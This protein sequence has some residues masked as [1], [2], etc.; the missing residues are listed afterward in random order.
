MRGTGS[1]A[2]RPGP[3]RPVPV[4]TYRLQVRPEFGYDDAAAVVDHLAALGVGHAYLSPVLQPTPGSA[5]GY[6]VVDHS[7][8]NEE[9]GGR[10]AFER[11]VDALHE[12]G[13]GAVADVVPNHMAV[14]TPANLNAAL[15]SVLR[16]GPRSPFARWF[17]VDWDS[18]DHALLMPVL[19]SRIGQVLGNGELSLDTSGDEPLLRYYD[20]VF[21]VRPG[22]ESLGLAELVDRQWYRLAHWRV[23]DEELNYRRFFDVDTLAA[24]RV[25]DPEVFDATHELL[26]ELL[27]A[28]RL[29]GLRIDH[30]DGL[31]DPRGYLHR[32]AER[33]GRSWVVVEKILEGDERLP[34]DWET[35]GTTGYDALLRIGGLFVDPQGAGPLQ[36]LLDEV[37]AEDDQ[38]QS[39]FHAVVERA[40]REVV[41][42]G[43][44]AEV[45]RLTDLLVSICHA[46][47]RLR[48]HTARALRECVVELLVAFDRY[49]AYVVP[50]EPAPP[51]A[52]AVL[53]HAA[54]VARDHL[55]EDRWETLEVVC[56]LLLGREVGTAG[57]RADLARAELVIRFQQTCGPVM[58]KGV[59]DTAF[60]RWHRLV[61]L[62]EVGGDPERLGVPADELHAW[63]GDQV[64][65]HPTAMTTL[66]THDTKRSEDVRARL[67][68][69]AE[70]PAEWA[71]AVR[72]WRTLAEPHRRPQLDGATEYLIWQ[73]LVG[74]WSLG[75]ATK[76]GPIS[77]DR[78]VAYLEKAVREA[79]LH[80]TWTSQDE[81][82]EDAVRGFATGVLGDDDVL[83]AVKAYCERTA[84]AARVAVL[85]QK[86]VQLT[87]PGVPDVYQGTELVDLSLVDPDNR[88]P[89]DYE[90]RRARL[91]RLDAGGH[92][93]DLDDEK[94]LVTSRALRVRREHPEAFVGESTTYAPLPTSTGH[95][96]AFARGDADGPRAVTL[97]TRLPL[98]LARYG[99]W[100]AHTVALPEGRWVDAL[101]GR[102]LPGGPVALSEALG[103]LPLALLVRR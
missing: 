86:L 11:L 48:D 3:G 4:S 60:Y 32:L 81:G 88:R 49:R 12:R 35:A 25:E 46:D 87:V 67:A 84:P 41:E 91:A 23:A 59:E 80:T 62:N 64:Q 18:P 79:K 6:D 42:H 63:C 55:P 95:A 53:E 9:A 19:G 37:T 69:L 77:A 31:A 102:E 56:E 101:T 76:A 90:V 16:D 97:A 85:G 52:I 33:T 92:P 17:D 73:T 94:L 20:H 44:Y 82:Y 74:T 54:A 39:S 36:A 45:H 26:L 50:G 70:A 29:D 5:H 8:L 96:V 93:Q 51:T 58:A 10:P 30:P 21:P 15:W 27:S 13:L 38:R 98:T 43:L 2:H 72:S 100:G 1:A 89:V 34:D 28:G 61:A 75:G 47:V 22:T 83:A 40:K 7:R 66:S 78:L 99:G 57:R 14:P 103:T 71:E 24:V 65:H 68:V